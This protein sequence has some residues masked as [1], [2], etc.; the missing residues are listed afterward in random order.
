MSA[1]AAMILGCAGPRLDPD[2]AAFLADA[3]PWGFILFARNVEGPA[4]VAALVT[5]L[6]AAVGR[7][8]PVLIDQEG[9]RVARLG[10]PHWT[11]WPDAGPHMA[12]IPPLHRAEAMR[13]RYRVIGAELAAL[14]I[15]VNCAPMVDLVRP[16]TH[17][18]LAPRMYGSV[19]AEVAALGRAVADGLMQA[20]VLPVL[21][22]IPGHGRTPLDS[23][24]ALPRVAADLATLEAEDFAPFRALADLGLGM[25]AHIVY[26]ALD[27]ERPA[28]LSPVVIRAIRG[29]I[30]FGGL[31]MSD[32]ISM[33]A[34]SGPLHDRAAAAIAAGCDVVLHCNGDRAETAAVAG[35]VPRLSGA[36][37]RRAEA[38][39]AARDALSGDMP[40]IPAELAALAALTGP[41][42]RHA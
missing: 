17:A 22:H 42:R 2:E 35:A 37:L 10:P 27:A 34:L 19:P 16:D 31:L 5:D 3:D 18:A 30:G 15:D 33:G 4:Q 36:A 23:H 32:D 38:A 21:K 29:A 1:P 28:T 11:G 6:R 26:E 41:E 25:T 24:E 14:G 13:R 8:A 9:G 12:A 20:G 7:R 39:L 40:D